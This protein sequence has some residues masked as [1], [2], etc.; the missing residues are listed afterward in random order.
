MVALRQPSAVVAGAVAAVVHHLVAAARL[1]ILPT[2]VLVDDVVVVGVA[3][4]A[5]AQVV[6]VAVVA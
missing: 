1:P 3:S 4:D 6:A 2:P 5:V